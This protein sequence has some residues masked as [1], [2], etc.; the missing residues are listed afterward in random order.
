MMDSASGLDI[1][2]S[3]TEASLPYDDPVSYPDQLEPTSEATEAKGSLAERIGSNKVYLLSEA[4]LA[5]RV[6]KVRKTLI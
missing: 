6:G 1:E 3:Y 2:S 5:A 4:A